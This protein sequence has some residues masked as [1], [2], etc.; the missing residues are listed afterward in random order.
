M[1]R[2]ALAGEDVIEAKTYGRGNPVR[3]LVFHETAN[4]RVG[5]NADAHARLQAS[6]NVRNASWHVQGDDREVVRSFE[7]DV[8]CWHAGDGDDPDGG[9]FNGEAY[10][11]CVNA[12][13]DYDAALALA[14]RWFRMRRAATGLGRSAVVQH[15]HFNGKD[16]PAIL[17]DRGGW[18]AFVAATDPIEEESMARSVSQ[19]IAHAQSMIGNRNYGGWCGKF[20]RECFGFPRSEERRVGNVTGVQT[21]ALP[22]FVQ[23]HHFNGK[24]CPAILRD[25]GGW[26]A[27]VAATDPIEEE[28][29]AR[30][31][32]QRIAHAQSMIGNRNYGGWCEKFVRECFGFPARNPSATIAWN[33]TRYRHRD[34]NNAPAGVPIF[35]ELHPANRNHGLGH[36]ALSVGGGYCSSTSVGPGGAIGKVRIADRTR[37]WQMTVRGW[38]EDY[39]GQRIYTRPTAPPS[40]RRSGRVPHTDWTVNVDG[41][42]GYYTKIA[43]Q[44]VL[45]HNG[46]KTHA[47]DGSFGRYSITSLQRFLRA[48]GQRGHAIDGRWGYWTT[49]SLQQWLR[50]RGYTGHAVDG[51]FGPYTVRSLQQALVDGAFFRR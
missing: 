19:R 12:D 8:R 34:I 43:L 50:D 27:F 28:S 26:E 36:V 10:E 7:S 15:H 20:V 47:L 24:D 30:S 48:Q 25:R 51:V 5:A 2:L 42:F 13:G 45:R 21:C 29:M 32:S 49:R 33:R 38:T 9:N 1:E 41:D 17:R 11:M 40:G 4:P 35:W 6:G 18:E 37:S 39:H 31:V 46:Y 14:V 16:C 3:F 44:N 22:I 23:H